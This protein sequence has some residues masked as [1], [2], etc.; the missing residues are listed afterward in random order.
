MKT[1]SEAQK[2]SAGMKAAMKEGIEFTSK[3]TQPGWLF[4]AF[5]TPEASHAVRDQIIKDGLITVE[6]CPNQSWL[7]L[8]P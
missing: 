8:Q 3:L 7:R 4:I 1:W 6:V 5:R 2:E